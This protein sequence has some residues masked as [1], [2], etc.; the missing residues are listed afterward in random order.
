M[1]LDGTRS[2]EVCDGFEAGMTVVAVDAV[3]ALELKE[4]CVLE[5]MVD[6]E[7]EAIDIAFSVCC[8]RLFTDCL[9]NCAADCQVM[10]VE[11]SKD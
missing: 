11:V 8:R 3:L 10:L 2:P 1:R 5:V 6:E 9:G 4:G 7:S